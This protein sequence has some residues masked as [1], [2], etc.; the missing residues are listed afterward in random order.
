[1][2]DGNKMSEGEAIARTRIFPQSRFGPRWMSGIAA[3]FVH[4]VMRLTEA[5]REGNVLL[6][7]ASWLLGRCFCKDFKREIKANPIRTMQANWPRGY[8]HPSCGRKLPFGYVL[9]TSCG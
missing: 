8:G 5:E 2:V 4:H 1:M 9:L 6:V 7:E 3:L